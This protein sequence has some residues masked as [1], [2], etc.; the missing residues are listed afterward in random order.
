MSL[1]FLTCEPDSGMYCVT[2]D[3]KYVIM[4][5][6]KYKSIHCTKYTLYKVYI[7]QRYEPVN[8]G[9]VSFD[10]LTLQYFINST[11]T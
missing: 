2:F 7:A 11:H 4:W 6:E 1:S 3:A 9:I 5:H 8:N 10:K